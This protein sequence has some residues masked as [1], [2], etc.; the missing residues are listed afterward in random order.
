MMALG[1]K[2]IL[3][4]FIINTLGFVS[5]INTSDKTDKY[6]ALLKDGLIGKDDFIKLISKDDSNTPTKDY[7]Y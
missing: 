1:V 3:I 5:K 4:L 6:I 2:S 7:I